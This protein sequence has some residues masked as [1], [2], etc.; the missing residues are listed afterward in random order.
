VT[1]TAPTARAAGTAPPGTLATLRSLL[2]VGA[3]PGRRLALSTA[4]GA[5]AAASTVGLLA[6]SGLLIDRAALRP[7]LYTLTVL[8]AAVQ[9]LA[10]ARGPL[11]YA[12]RLVAHDAAFSVTARLRVWL[13]DRLEPLSPAGL[14]GWR[15]GE[16]LARATGD[17]NELEDLYLRG[18]SPL[19]VAATTGALGVVVVAA[20][21]PAAGLL[22]AG[23]L[24]VGLVVPPALARAAARG[25]REAA[26][27]GELAADVVDLLQG[28]ADLVALGCAGDYLER[29][30]R[31]DQ[32]LGRLRR[33]RSVV[34][35][36]AAAAT[37]ACA[38]AAVVGTLVLGAAAVH[39]HRMAGVMLAVLPLVAMGTFE[40][41]P[42]VSDA[43]LR[44]E[45]HVA[46]GRRLL[47]LERLPAPVTDPED[48]RPAPAGSPSVSLVGARLRYGADRPWALDGADLDVAPGGRVAVVG[49][50]GAGK[51][52]VVNALL[53][54]YGLEAG[55]AALGGIPL[56]QMAQDDV[57]AVV[58]WLP[59]DAH[60]FDTT[61]GANISLARP[62]A[63]DEE[64][65]RAAD[66]AQLRPWLD[67]LPEG[68][69]TAVGER[70]AQV[71]GGQRQRIALARTL[72]ADAGVLVLDE[73]T[74]GLDEAMAERLLGD[75]LDAADG[76]TVVLVSH[77]TRD[78]RGFDAV[79]RME[80]GKVVS[81]GPPDPDGTPHDLPIS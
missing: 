46:A 44:L 18:V 32:E 63:S 71:S 73:P 17:V 35:G 41:V 77:R 56:E 20:L 45:G 59:Q 62:G 66:L 81:L 60:L 8:M 68:L 16:L 12:E 64:V 42:A 34:A 5:G 1:A 50:S 27:R 19:V 14:G 10:L 65:A 52:S 51:S 22:L 49:P 9:L 21:L 37:V 54:F 25:G 80:A 26:V 57:R 36:A 76:R 47:D 15:T 28:A 69:D 43:V 78:T 2:A 3:P 74:A 58:G 11:R 33:R 48:P 39:Q 29:A 79:A 55:R 23:C 6:C 31:A 53:R 4:L 38:G 24:V 72:L 13:Y 70:G 67:S 61:I 7:A 75:V 40:T 30:A